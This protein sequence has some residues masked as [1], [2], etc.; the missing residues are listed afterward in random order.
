MMLPTKSGHSNSPVCGAHP[1]ES[2][3]LRALTA[4]ISTSSTARQ[5]AGSI[6]QRQTLPL[7]PAIP[8]IFACRWQHSHSSVMPPIVVRP[9]T[10]A[11]YDTMWRLLPRIPALAHRRLIRQSNPV[12]AQVLVRL[13]IHLFSAS[14]EWFYLFIGNKRCT[15]RIGLCETSDLGRWCTVNATTNTTCDKDTLPTISSQC[16]QVWPPNNAGTGPGDPPCLDF[17]N[18]AAILYEGVTLLF[19]TTLYHRQLL[20][21]RNW[22]PESNH[23]LGDGLQSGRYRR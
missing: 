7:V 4:C 10:G 17:Y 16:R 23:R 21:L 18:T 20:E 6:S 12:L 13:S 8:G 1:G 9:H 14:F 2:L 5:E 3:C 15:G 22:L 11:T 19:P